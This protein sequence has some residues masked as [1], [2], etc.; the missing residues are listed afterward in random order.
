M[1]VINKKGW[2]LVGFLNGFML[3]VRMMGCGV[4]IFNGCRSFW[5]GV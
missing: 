4:I 1:G 2:E 3:E 5:M